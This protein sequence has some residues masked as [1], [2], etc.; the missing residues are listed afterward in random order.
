M[1]DFFL[2]VKAIYANSFANIKQK[3]GKTVV[4]RNSLLPM[5]LTGV[6]LALVFSG[7]PLFEIAV[8]K[9]G[10][11][12]LNDIL[13]YLRVY[14]SVFLVYGFLM[15]CGN[16][17]PIFFSSDDE[18]FLPLPIKGGKLFLARFTLSLF[19]SMVYSFLPICALFAG[20]AI[21]AELPG[22]SIFFGIVLSLFLVVS[23]TALSFL[24]LDVL[25]L[26]FKGGKK[27]K[28]S[29][30][31]AMV[32][33][34]LAFILLFVLSFLDPLNSSETE[35]LLQLH[36]AILQ[37]SGNFYF[38]DWIVFLPFE[39]M[40]FSSSIS[41]LFFFLTIG[42]S[43]LVLLLAIF[44]G[45]RFYIPALV[46][47]GE[48]KRKKEKEGTIVEKTEK[49]F[50]FAYRRSF[51]FFL[52][53]ELGNFK[54]HSNVLVSSF[55][56]SFAMIVSMAVIIPS[57]LT[58]LPE[59]T[60]PE[61]LTFLFVFSLVMTSLFEPYFSFVSLSLEGR[62]FLLLKTYPIDRKC[63]LLS[64]VFFGTAFSFILVF[65]MMLTFALLSGF[66]ALETIFSLLALLAYSLFTNF[67][68]LLFGIRFAVFSFDNSIELLQRGWGARLVSLTLF[69]APLPFIGVVA[70]TSILLPDF[71]FLGPLIL[72]VLLLLLV[73]LLYRLCL[74]S[75][76]KLLKKD[77]SI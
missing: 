57:V 40:T 16:N 24:F 23:L 27:R 12:A 67:L 49:A 46:Y 38:I 50:D 60:L 74:S 20:A 62:S 28:F 8:A 26:V 35:T 33:S 75:F 77:I 29:T 10:G 13:L 7:S 76:D 19:Y 53:R 31:L 69:F 17:I 1:R 61:N 66:G 52:K 34:L 63:F 15:A 56:S 58:S 70:L 47:R 37:F 54:T 65:A 43:V 59:G 6:V 64:K 48:K 25:F 45:N 42:I 9:T 73:Y 11:L 3:K 21:L 71:L 30:I 14:L 2:L 32:F 4:K 44:I 22:V 55:V 68:S 41:V 18:D 39:A 36:Q 72:F 5:L 51:L